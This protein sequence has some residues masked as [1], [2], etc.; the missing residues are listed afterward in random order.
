M[1]CEVLPQNAIGAEALNLGQDSSSHNSTFSELVKVHRPQVFRICLRITR[2]EHDAEDAA[3]DCFLRAFTHFHQFEGRAQFRTWL[4]TIARNSA[5]MLLR[6]KRVKQELPMD[7]PDR[8]G[9]IGWLEP[10]DSDP[11]QLSRVLYAE[12][13]ARFM[14]SIEALPA[15]LR[16][17]ADL[18][19]L[20]ELTLQEAGQILDITDACVKS[21][22]FRARRRL[23]RFGKG[24]GKANVPHHRSINGPVEL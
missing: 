11:D 17:A 21:R 16:S 9:E 2:N 13:H 5:L 24:R 23:S 22:L 8:D 12:S 20:N 1:R 18:I 15:T 4:T 14:R 3:Q 19:I 7:M 6:K 10:S